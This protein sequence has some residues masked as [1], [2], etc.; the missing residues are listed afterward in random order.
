MVVYSTI[1]AINPGVPET[2][3]HIFSLLES[4]ESRYG[5][6]FETLPRI[7]NGRIYILTQIDRGN[8][9]PPKEKSVF[10]M[11]SFFLV[12]IALILLFAMLM[13]FLIARSITRSVF[14]L[15]KATK[16]IASGE[17][18]LEIDMKGIN[19]ITSLTESF[20]HM[21][22]ALKD[23]EQRRRRFIMG[24]THDLKTPLALIKGYAEAIEDGVASDPTAQLNSVKIIGAKA[25]QLEGMIDDLLD[26]VRVDSGEWRRNLVPVNFT[27]FLTT[28][29]KRIGPDAEILN[30]RIETSIDLPPNI[31]VPMDERLVNRALENLVNN[32]IRYTQKNGRIGIKAVSGD[33][34]IMVTISDD[35]VGIDEKDLPHIFEIFYRGT[36][37]RREQG[38]GLGLSIVKG[39]IDSHKWEI[40]VLSEKGRGSRFVIT[41]PL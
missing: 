23:E 8:R 3:E 30:R 9:S 20:N 26:F 2:G 5:Y 11:F 29:S 19:E 28:F 16:R 37:S 12:L 39:I 25:D 14:V 27:D 21:R 24:I 4:V 6:A 15:E 40:T 13:S 41:I 38:M 36:S 32:A 31:S 7:H 35:G 33:N 34:S 17:L 1:S 10:P 18:D 22:L